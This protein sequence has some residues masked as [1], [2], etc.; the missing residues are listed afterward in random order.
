MNFGRQDFARDVDASPIMTDAKFLYD[1]AANRSTTQGFSMFHRRTAVDV[2]MINPKLDD[3]FGKWMWTNTLQQV[4]D[5]L[6]KTA[7]REKIVEVLN[8]L[9]GAASR[10]T[11]RAHV[12]TLFVRDLLEVNKFLVYRR[13]RARHPEVQA[14]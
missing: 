13:E 1:A 5:G 2:K 9:W 3:I 8:R 12:G 4:A 10:S 7:V 6:T 14:L 11:I